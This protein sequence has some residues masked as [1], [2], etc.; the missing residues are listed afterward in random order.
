MA[1]F[2][3]LQLLSSSANHCSSCPR[4]QCAPL[5]TSTQARSGPVDVDPDIQAPELL[6]DLF[7]KGASLLLE[8]L[9]GVFEGQGPQLSSPQDEQQATHAAKLTREEARLDFSR[10]ALSLHNTVRGFAGWPGT[11]ASFV[12]RD[13]DTGS[14]EPTE[15]KIV[16]TRA[17]DSD[18]GLYKHLQ[19]EAGPNRVSEPAPGQQGMHVQWDPNTGDMLLPC[20]GGESVLRVFVVQPPTKK[21]IAARDFRNGLRQKEVCLAP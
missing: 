3:Q 20:Q 1:H 15:I 19:S 9:P 2:L 16:R 12:L 21:A 6:H 8:A 5:S 18:T 11:S 17:L 14:L 10:P 13:K 7:A 4:L